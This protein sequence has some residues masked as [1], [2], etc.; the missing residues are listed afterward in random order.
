M[1]TGFSYTY[2]PT[3]TKVYGPYSREILEAKFNRLED[4]SDYKI[5]EV[6]ERTLERKVSI[7]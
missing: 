7:I 4:L 3:G 1:K 2:A 5:F 6:V